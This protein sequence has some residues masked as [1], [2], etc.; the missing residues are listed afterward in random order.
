MDSTNDD[1]EGNL[2]APLQTVLSLWWN[3]HLKEFREIWWWVF[4]W[5]LF[6][7]IFAHAFAF[8]IS[9]CTLHKHKQGRWYC[10]SIVIMGFFTPLTEGVISSAL[11]A[12]VYVSLGWTMVPKFALVWGAGQTAAVIALSWTRLLSTL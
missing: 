10:L 8:L 6:S 11:I 4:L 5:A 2:L 3:G 1:N 9:F 7:S 12:G